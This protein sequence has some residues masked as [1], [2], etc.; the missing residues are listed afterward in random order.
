ME[1]GHG[2]LHSR[3]HGN[4]YTPE[5][6]PVFS[7]LIE[8][9]IE[10]EYMQDR[11]RM[12]S[13]NSPGRIGP[14]WAAFDPLGGSKINEN[15]QLNLSLK[16][17]EDRRKL[18]GGLDELDRSTDQSGKMA[19]FD[20][21][22]QQALETILGGV[23]RNALDLSKEDPRVVERYD[24]SHLRTGWLNPRPSTLGKRLLMARRLVEAGSRFVTVGMAGWD[25]H[26]NG[27]HPGVVAGTRMLGGQVDHAVSAFIDDVEARGLSKKILLVITGEFGRTVKIQAQGGRDHW[28]GLGTL[29]FAGGG[30]PMGQV[31][32]ASE[33]LHNIPKDEPYMLE[34]LTGTLLRTIFDMGKLRLADGIPNDLMQFATGARGIRELVG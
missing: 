21:H 12:I 18:L 3:L 27:K 8:P 13:G 20:K 5:G 32:G 10:D 30:M 28:P 15:L 16:R 17:L 33:K 4:A 2:A 9:E 14:T 26:G 22:L 29:V 19:A 6:S 11:Q 1:S 23:T 24:T 25:N 34:H 31:I 7:Q